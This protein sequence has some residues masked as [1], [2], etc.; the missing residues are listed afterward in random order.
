MKSQKSFFCILLLLAVI[1]SGYPVQSTAQVDFPDKAELVLQ[2]S[3]TSNGAIGW[4]YTYK[5]E[6]K[7][8]LKGELTDSVI[9]LF[10]LGNNYDSLLYS[11]PVKHNRKTAD[12]PISYT[13]SF[14][15]IENDKPYV[16][17]KNAFMDKKKRTWELIDL[18][19]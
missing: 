11:N 9:I 3:A 6:V 19:K 13:A 5:C 2:I 7:K 16:N 14:K 10:T 8:V 4:G 18:K 1:L 12:P 17:C 15:E